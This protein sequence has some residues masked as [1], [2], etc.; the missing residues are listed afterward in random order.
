MEKEGAERDSSW[1]E[2]E[3]EER[4]RNIGHG[5]RFFL[6][7]RLRLQPAFGFLLFATCGSFSLGLTRRRKYKDDWNS[8]SCGETLRKSQKK[9]GFACGFVCGC[10]NFSGLGAAGSQGIGPIPT[11]IQRSTNT[12]LDVGSVEKKQQE[13][14]KKRET[15]SDD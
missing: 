4:T 9:N 7:L 2:E 1:R 5:E 14:G 10:F 15:A 3:V 11:P 8:K 12:Y 6:S 13:L